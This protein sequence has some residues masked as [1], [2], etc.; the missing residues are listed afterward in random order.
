MNKW[1]DE[2]YSFQVEV[3]AVSHNNTTEHHCRNGE[4]V[5]DVF[6]CG[7]GCPVNSCGQGICSKT[8]MILFPMMEAV[9]SG[10][11]LLNLGGDSPTSKE[12]LCP[13]GVVKYRLT[14]QKQND[15]NF[16]LNIKTEL[17]ELVDSIQYPVLFGIWRYRVRE[18]DS[19]K[20]FKEYIRIYNEGI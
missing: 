20:S 7:Y 1:Y 14:S 11:S 10:G 3:I 12:F 13:D 6:A 17:S 15:D 2:Q 5:G 9:R 16:H 19:T 4:Q 18:Q 8:M